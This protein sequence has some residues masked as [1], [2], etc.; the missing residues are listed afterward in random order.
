MRSLSESDILL[1]FTYAPA[2]LGHLRVT[3]AL[4]DGLPR[5]I[6]SVLLGTDDTK[7]TYWHRLT[8][9][10][11]FFR[12]IMEWFTTKK[13]GD[14]FYAFY[15]WILK[16]STRRLYQQME[17][18][19]SQQ[20]QEKKTVVVVSTHF[21]L[22]HQ[23]AAIKSRL[24]KNL[25]IKLVLIVQVTDATAMEIW[26]VPGADLISVPSEKVRAELLKY[27]EKKRLGKTKIVVLP[28]PLSQKLGEPLEEKEYEMRLKQ[29]SPDADAK[30]KI[31]IPIS[32][33]AVGLS[34]YKKLATKLARINGRVMIYLVVR[35]NIYTKPFINKMKIRDYVTV[36]E[37]DTDK[38][39][40]DSYEKLYQEEVIGLEIVKPSEQAFKTLFAPGQ[41]GG[42]V[43]LLNEAVGRQEQD[44]LNFLLE[45]KLLP[46]QEDQYQWENYAQG[47]DEQPKGKDYREYGER[48]REWRAIKLT[49]NP[50]KDAQMIN[51]GIKAGIFRKMSEPREKPESKDPELA[52]NGVQQFWEKVDGLVTSVKK[53]AI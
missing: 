33:A 13:N 48:A 28:Y 7:I 30:I 40:V 20:W 22:A 26:Y 51:W 37:N 32:G 31:A 50:D 38:K 25:K 45:H 47:D 24:E 18:L 6:N 4:Y 11:P 8:S 39:V 15:I 53:S 49:N 42:V 12:V 16:H 19:I 21:G 14:W 2:G 52:S 36:I 3:D 43:L 17:D 23:I 46:S 10:S 41:R 29:Y 5:Q 35:N 44:N 27:A 1:V 34:Y 9:V